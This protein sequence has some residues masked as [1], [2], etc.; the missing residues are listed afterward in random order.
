MI[1]RKKDRNLRK[2]KHK[3]HH[4]FCRETSRIS[5]LFLVLPLSY[6]FVENTTYRSFSLK[7]HFTLLFS[8]PR[9]DDRNF[10]DKQCREIV[11]VS[12]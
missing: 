7:P 2:L 10:H 11:N 4:N 9:T 8:F 1:Q 3:I 12:Q 5:P 6:N